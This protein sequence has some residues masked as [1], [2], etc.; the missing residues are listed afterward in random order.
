MT[1]FI[2][3]R[4]RRRPVDPLTSPEFAALRAV[5]WSLSQGGLPAVAER[6]AADEARIAAFFAI[7]ELLHLLE[8]FH[9][10]CMR[11]DPCHLVVNDRGRTR[12]RVIIEI[13]MVY[14]GVPPS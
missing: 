7:Q 1:P 10:A 12:D 8:D 3:R 2:P 14:E 13:Q 11:G 9:R 5:H 4:P 6:T